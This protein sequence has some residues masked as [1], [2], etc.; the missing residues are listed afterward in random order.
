MAPKKSRFS[1]N[2]KFSRKSSESFLEASST[3]GVWIQAHASVPTGILDADA[4]R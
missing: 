4:D 3:A 2:L 1:W